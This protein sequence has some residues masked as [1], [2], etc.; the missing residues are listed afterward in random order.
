MNTASAP[1]VRFR[2]SPLCIASLLACLA[3]LLLAVPG[4]A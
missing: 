2:G 3:L 4:Q 1:L